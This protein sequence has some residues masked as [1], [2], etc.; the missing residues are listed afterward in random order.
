MKKVLMIAYYYPPLA[1]AGVFRTLKFTKYLPLFDFQPYVLTVKNPMYP[2]R[3]TTLVNEIP[4]EVKVFRTFSFEHKVLRAPR[5]LNINLK[6]FY[7]PDVNIGWIPFAVNI[8]TKII[9][10]ENIDIIFATAP[11]WTSLIIGFLLKKRTKKPLVIDFR[12]PWTDNAFVEY[13]TKLHECI[14]RKIEEKIVAHADYI[15]VVSNLMKKNLVDRYPFSESK[16]EVI[17]NGFDSDDFKILEIHE[18]ANKF[19]VTH[20]GSIY[21]L[22][23]ARPLLFALKELIKEKA[24]LSNKLEIIFVGSYGKETPRLV[25][26]LGLENIVKLFT[27]ASHEACLKIMLSSHVLLLLTTIEDPRAY[28]MVPGKLFEYLASRKPILAITPENGEAA[29]LIKSLN[30]GRVVSPN[31]IK[32]IKETIFELFEKWE[33]GELPKITCDLS[34]Y[35]RKFLTQRLAQIFENVISSN[36]K[37]EC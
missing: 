31:N 20:T 7:I 37:I 23:T 9:R 19:R 22:R 33:R 25:K 6:W 5:L 28:S 14:E 4:P 1:G 15:T 3:D 34:K 32:L 10:K 35:E 8:G 26:M 30:A 24:G 2:L 11:I 27:Y 29:N 13:P 12:D 17:T 36:Q 16:I 21:G 18:Q